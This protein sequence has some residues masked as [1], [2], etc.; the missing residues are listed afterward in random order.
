MIRL[1]R[2]PLW[3]RVSA[4][5]GLLLLATSEGLAQRRRDPLTQSEIDQVRDASW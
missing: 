1:S 5:V 3:L 2:L 4:S